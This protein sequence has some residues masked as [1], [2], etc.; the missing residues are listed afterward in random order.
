MLAILL[1]MVL[2]LGQ[3]LAV[4]P[5]NAEALRRGLKG[6]FRAALLVELGSCFGDGLWAVLAFTGLSALLALP[7]M[8]LA[9]SVLG[10]ILLAWLAIQ[11]WR[12][13]RSLTIDPGRLARQTSELPGLW[14]GLLLGVVNPGSAVFWVGV[15][16]TVL[17]SRL[18]DLGPTTLLE[19]AIGYY[20]ALLG[21]SFGFSAFAW[22]LGQRLSPAAQVWIHRSIA[23]F[24]GALA[25]FSLMAVT[26]ELQQRA[27]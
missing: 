18:P 3:C 17:A 4:G 2:S 16:A 9:G 21:W 13:A 19:F 27:L 24:M 7:F 14:A 26:R 10:F 6:G 1:G 23:V 25:G 15:G 22:Q 5:V 12:D 11:G 20:I 8:D